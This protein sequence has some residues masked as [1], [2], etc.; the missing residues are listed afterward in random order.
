MTVVIVV[1][2]GRAHGVS[3]SCHPG[4]FCHIRKPHSSL[5]SEKAIPVLRGFLP[6]RRKGS[7]IYQEDVS[8]AVA[9]EVKGGNASRHSFNQVLLRSRAVLDSEVQAC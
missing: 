5:V 4:L 3:F 6:Q 9:V 2:S 8:Q 7:T 1:S